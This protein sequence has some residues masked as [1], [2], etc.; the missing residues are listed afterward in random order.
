MFLDSLRNSCYCSR[1]YRY[2]ED[3]GLLSYASV[4]VSNRDILPRLGTQQRIEMEYPYYCE[5]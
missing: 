1:R 5:V 2:A 4:G 3:S